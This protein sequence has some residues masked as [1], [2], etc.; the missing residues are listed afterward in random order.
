MPKKFPLEFQRDV[1][2]VARRGGLS[3]A[4]IAAD[5]GISESTVKRWLAQADV[6]DG[7]KDGLTSSEQ[8]ELVLLRRR[9]RRLEMENEILRRAAAYFA[10]E[11]LPK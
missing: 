9:N 5:F 8:N 6:D 11:S 2:A 3:R 10:A 4:E 7:V 1:V